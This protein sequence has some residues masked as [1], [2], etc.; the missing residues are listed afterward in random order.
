MPVNPSALT[1]LPVSDCAGDLLNA[2]RYARGL[3]AF[4]RRTGT[5]ITIGI[6]GGWGSGKTSLMNMLAERLQ[7][8]TSG[9]AEVGAI[10][11]DINAWEHSLFRA[12]DRA[13]VAYSLLAGIVDAILGGIEEVDLMGPA[14]SNEGSGR[15]GAGAEVMRTLGR[16][17]LGASAV[18]ADLAL[19]GRLSGAADLAGS[20][21]NVLPAT[22][23]DRSSKNEQKV[24]QRLDPPARSIASEVSALRVQLQAL[25]SQA[26]ERSQGRVDRFVVL[27]DDLDRV[28]PE[29]AVEILDVLKNI[30]VVSGC[31]FVL[32]IDFDVVVKGLSK[33]F[34]ERSGANERE[35]RQ[36]FDKI[37]QVPFTM[38]VAQYQDRFSGYVSDA[39]QRF[40][41]TEVSAGTSILLGDA[42][43]SVTDGSPRSVKRII[44]TLSLL[45][46]IRQI[47][48]A[49]A[50]GRERS[51]R[52]IAE[53]E[54]VVRF[55]VVGL[56][57][58]Y[59]DVYEELIREPDLARWTASGEEDGKEGP[60]GGGW[61]S[62]VREICAD[63]PWLSDREDQV[64]AGLQTLLKALEQ[65]DR[66]T[67]SQLGTPALGLLSEVLEA[68]E[69]TS[70]AA[71]GES[72]G[73]DRARVGYRNDA[74]TRI[75]HE[76][77]GELSALM[78][79]RSVVV[80]FDAT[81]SY[82]GRAGN[83]R[84]N[85]LFEWTMEGS[86]LGGGS[87]LFERQPDRKSYLVTASIL[88]AGEYGVR[89]PLRAFL[90][91]APLPSSVYEG[92]DWLSLSIGAVDLTESLGEASQRLAKS[93]WEFS[94]ELV[95]G[96]ERLLRERRA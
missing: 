43:R 17:A 68:S 78:G 1:D 92:Q 60:S 58:S 40:F 6:Q 49:A 3:A 29:T 48:P 39:I 4:I 46:L 80:D 44:N 88:V 11:V 2:D 83:G 52:E 5:P 8:K 19:G 95:G 12:T 67:S 28:P 76:F 53:A 96:M 65:V 18:A 26:L 33:K 62:R 75:C 7:A 37:I 57:V 87:L 56:Q 72:T 70:V 30:L 51:S 85:R 13:A 77:V 84:G 93:F 79:K 59:S 69:V 90:K 64:A 38:P 42:A 9:A 15:K 54:L 45:E 82:A 27:V 10:V 61:R 32:A 86:R 73:L 50:A 21:I 16:I 81:R 94:S 71:H 14:D 55:V 22:S 23:G 35:F 66:G 36:Y 47:E 20:F 24:I 31:V 89:T 41:G 91:T 34:G 63:D 74:I 25:I